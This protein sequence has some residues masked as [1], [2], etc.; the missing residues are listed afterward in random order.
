MSSG[1]ES[2]VL[3]GCV[4]NFYVASLLLALSFVLVACGSEPNLI[5]GESAQAT[6]PTVHATAAVADDSAPFEVVPDAGGFV[7]STDGFN[8]N[9]HPLLRYLEPNTYDPQHPGTARFVLIDIAGEPARLGSDQFPLAVIS[10]SGYAGQNL[11]IEYVLSY[12]NFNQNEFGEI[13][14][15]RC[16]G[17][18]GHFVQ[19]NS[20]SYDFREGQYPTVKDLGFDE[21]SIECGEM[22]PLTPANIFDGTVELEFDD[23]AIT[24]VSQ[25]SEG[26]IFRQIPLRSERQRIV[27]AQPSTTAAATTTTVVDGD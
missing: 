17:S 24:V 1:D 7:E 27:D 26:W 25:D 19:Q 12:N 8:I 4:R 9:D 23:T 5:V 13:G 14:Y 2:S 3:S 18:R 22:P 11:P 21:D 10:I 16:K 6:Q 20:T 15:G